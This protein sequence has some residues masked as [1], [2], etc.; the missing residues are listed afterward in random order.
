M[1]KCCKI[2]KK[3]FD[4]LQ[5]NK[6]HKGNASVKLVNKNE[7]KTKTSTMDIRKLQKKKIKLVTIFHNSFQSQMKRDLEYALEILL[8]SRHE[9]CDLYDEDEQEDFHFVSNCALWNVLDITKF[10]SYLTY[11]KLCDDE[12]LSN[13]EKVIEEINFNFS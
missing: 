9:R 10:C 8:L 13:I 12:F 6:Q 11:E 3:I 2:K 4:F 7:R 5:E 1:E